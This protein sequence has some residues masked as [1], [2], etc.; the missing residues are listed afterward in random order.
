MRTPPLVED[1]QRPGDLIRPLE[2][3]TRRGRSQSSSSGHSGAR[4]RHPDLADLRRNLRFS[5]E[6][7]KI[8]ITWMATQVQITS[9]KQLLPVS[10][11]ASVQIE[12]VILGILP[13]LVQIYASGVSG[14]TGSFVDKVDINPP[15]NTYRAIIQLPAGAAFFIH[16]CPR[17][18]TNGVLDDLMDH[19][20]WETFCAV[21]PFTTQ[22][23]PDPPPHPKPPAPTIGSVQSR[24]ATLREAGK[25]DVHWTATTDF[26]LYHF[27]WRE[28][29]QE[30]AQIEINSGGNSGVFTVSPALPGR[31]YVFKVQGCIS[32][33]I[34]L[35]DCSP[36]SGDATFVMPANTRSLRE[37]LRLSEA[38]LDP[39]IRSLGASVYGS[40]IRAAMH[41]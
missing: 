41:V 7:E 22:A 14:Q 39:G 37:F 12:F 35:D 19:Q 8:G 5:K 40:G 36:F 4:D 33:L 32:K 2:F 18:M 26:D 10:A 13:D 6:V 16:L 17:T 23:P 21:A 34:G 1:P 9:I 38:Q 27:M 15:E 11:L 25:I 28:Q 20:P 31:T 29:S 30:W 3:R 24:Q